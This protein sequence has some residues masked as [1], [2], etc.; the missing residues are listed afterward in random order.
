MQ[1]GFRHRPGRF[2]IMLF[3]SFFCTC[4]PSRR[5]KSIEP[6]PRQ[7]SLGYDAKKPYHARRSNRQSKMMEIKGIGFD[8]F[9][10]THKHTLTL[11]DSVLINVVY[12]LSSAA[13]LLSPYRRYFVRFQEVF[14][15][16]LTFISYNIHMPTT[17]HGLV[18]MVSNP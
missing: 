14:H 3:R 7:F 2:Q 18:S 16:I 12:R 8:S 17:P 6:Q 11:S 1:C 9:S 4:C 5:R 10:H 15:A 13:F